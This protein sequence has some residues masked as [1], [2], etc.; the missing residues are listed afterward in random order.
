[1]IEKLGEREQAIALLE[2]VRADQLEVLG[3]S[4]GHTL[5]VQNVLDG[6]RSDP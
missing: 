6:L 2:A 5:H 3:E 1:V 4:H